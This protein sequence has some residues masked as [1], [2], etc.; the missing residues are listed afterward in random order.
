MGLRATLA[1][2]GL[3]RGHGAAGVGPAVETERLCG[4]LLVGAVPRPQFRTVAES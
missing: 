3:G 1:R 2:D 4:E